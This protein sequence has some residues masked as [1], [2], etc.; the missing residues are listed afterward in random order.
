MDFD[1][2]YYNWNDNLAAMLGAKL[3]AAIDSHEPQKSPT[4]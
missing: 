4:F 1:K 2:V 3:K